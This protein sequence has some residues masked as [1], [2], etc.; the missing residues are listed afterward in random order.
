MKIK[1]KLLVTVVGSAIAILSISVVFL[2]TFERTS[3]IESEHA[4]LSDLGRSVLAMRVAINSLDTDQVDGARERF[5][6]RKQDLA[7]AF[8]RIKDIAILPGLDEGLAKAIEV[9]QNLRPLAF[10]EIDSVDAL[11]EKLADYVQKYY[12]ET[13]SVSVDRFYTDEWVR[14]KEGVDEVF[15]LL[16]DFKG[17]VIGANDTIGSVSDTLYEQDALIAAVLAGVRDGSTLFAVLFAGAVLLALILFV[18]LVNRSIGRRVGSIVRSI[19][20]IGEGDFSAELAL[21]GGDEIADIAAT[22]NSLT[23]NLSGLVTRNQGMAGQLRDKGIDLASQMEET[24]AS[25]IQINASIGNI[26]G[27]LE[28]QTAALALTATAI[29][30]S[31]AG[32]EELSSKVTRQT[33]VLR[34]ASSGVEEMIGNVASV[35][36]DS[37]SAMVSTE[38]LLGL[39][40]EGRARIEAVAAAVDDIGRHS[41]DLIDATKLINDIAARTNLLS[42]N[43]AIEASHAGAAGA[44]FS[45]VADEIRKLANQSSEQAKKI[46]KDLNA[47]QAGIQD[48]GQQAGSARSAFAAILEQA[49][50]VNHQAASLRDAMARQDAGAASVLAGIRELDE[51]G[52][53]VAEATA[54]LASTARSIQRNLEALQTANAQ[55]NTSNEEIRAGTGEINKAIVAVRETTSSTSE[56]IDELARSLAAYRAR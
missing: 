36:G 5:E 55:V 54:G 9:T 41:V 7:T 56:L 33:E 19:K 42:M 35:S 52:A 12:L 26:R 30:E 37:K 25:V 18:L 50:G 24:A 27:Q 40:E 13:R 38:R 11:F 49:K 32:S 22:L 1:H 10:G 2:S 48:I 4:I 3:R 53:E 39:S 6:Q 34:L 23:A 31:G 28:A 46:T 29:Q 43:A 51:L 8:D 14:T 45:V 20:P 21:K 47:V 17:A 16:G 15:A 44:G